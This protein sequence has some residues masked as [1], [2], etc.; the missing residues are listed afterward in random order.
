MGAH[1]H[2]EHCSAINTKGQSTDVYSS[3]DASRG[4]RAEGTK[5]ISKGY[6]LYY[7]IY[8]TS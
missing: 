2:H 8:T 1:P 7:G 6:L 4:H 5:L 3:L